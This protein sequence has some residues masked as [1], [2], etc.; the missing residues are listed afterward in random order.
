[1]ALEWRID[2][3]VWVNQ[4]AGFFQVLAAV[5]DAKEDREAAEQA[6]RALMPNFSQPTTPPAD[7]TLPAQFAHD[8][9]LKEAEMGLTEVLKE[10]RNVHCIRGEESSLD[11]LLDPLLEQEDLDSQYLRFAD[12]KE[13]EREI[14]KIV[15]SGEDVGE[16][17][18]DEPE[19][20]EPEFE[21]SKK[22]ALAAAE[23]LAKV[24][25]SRPDFEV[26]LALGNN[27]REFRTVLKQEME[28]SK[29]QTDI[30][31]F[32]QRTN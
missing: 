8:R 29:V 2:S 32:F 31:S 30:S 27:L 18:D 24:M 14:L 22:D 15:Q 9:H 21:F 10:M 16:E 6:V 20:E 11:E 13:G 5:M 28:E 12:A 17:A 1:M 19:A 23:L 3:S 7:S 26:A 25:R 4:S